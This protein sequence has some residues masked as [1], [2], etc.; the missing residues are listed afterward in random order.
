MSKGR[1][2]AP[3]FACSGA[4]NEKTAGASEDVC[5]LGFQRTVRK[6]IGRRVEKTGMRLIGKGFSFLRTYVFLWDKM[7]DTSLSGI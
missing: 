1:P 5:G 2:E 6:R 7:W 4:A 3:P